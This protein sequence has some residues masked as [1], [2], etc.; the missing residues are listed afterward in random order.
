[1]VSMADYNFRS[2]SSRDFE[3]LA[4][5]LLQA[6][7]KHRL[8]SF[9]S[10]PDSGIDFRYQDKNTKLIVQ[11]KHYAESGFAA[12]TSA[13]RRKERQKIDHLAPTRYVLA[14][15][16]S[17]SPANKDEIMEILAPYCHET[18]DIYGQEDLNNLLSQY[19]DIERK[20][21]KLWLTSETVLRRVLDAGIFSDSDAH[22]ER[23]RL[24]LRR[25][26]PNPSFQR[27]V[28]LLD[29][30]HYCIIAGIPGIGKTT[31]AQVLLADLVD[32]QGFEA[33]RIAHDLDEIRAVKNSKRKQVFYFDDFLGKT[34]LEKLQKNED[35]RLVELIEEVVLNQNWRF[36][37]TTR[38]YILNRAKFSYEAFAQ[39]PVDFTP[40]VIKLDDYTRLI[41]AKIL[42]N[43]I[44]FSELPKAHKLALLQKKGYENILQHRNYNPRVIEYMTQKLHACAVAPSIYLS[45]FTDS[46]EHPTRIWD[47]AFRF[48]ISEAARHVLLVLATLPN[49]IL[50]TDLENS[51][52]TF[53]RFRQIRFGFPT[54]SEDW[55]RALKELDGNFITTQRVGDKISVSF[56]NPSIRDFLEDFLSNSERDV[57]DLVSGAHFY[58]Q[59]VNL[60][61]GRGGHRYRAINHHH[62]EF[63]RHLARN[64]FGPTASAIRQL[65]SHN[66]V[67]GLKHR[68]VSNESRTGFALRVCKELKHKG[69]DQFLKEILDTLETRWE[70]GQGDKE[71]LVRLL[72]S[73]TDY[74]LDRGNTAFVMAKQC[75]SSKTE[76]IEDFRALAKFMAMYP[77]EV[78]PTDLEVLRSKFLEFAREYSEGWDDDPDWLREAAGDLEL[79]G[80]TL[81]VDVTDFTGKLYSS[82]NDIESE[83][84]DAEP[85]TNDEEPWDPEES[86]SAS[87]RDDVH[88]MFEGLREEIEN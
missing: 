69:G 37:L 18:S 14:T 50:L 48:Q 29:R 66:E 83:R 12:L 9:S 36:I 13:L 81:E 6:N 8:E 30:S 10:G 79:I 80:E 74:G 82:A 72:K 68:A 27:A 53:Y 35:Q 51:F 56:H 87:S 71:D 1:M 62:E 45:E 40:C 28:E 57:L 61:E 19:P 7:I 32:R 58:E 59:Y 20:H 46:L 11:C 60:W 86:S 4:R 85:E 24:R 88:D 17:L 73:L 54:A 25:Y 38:E 26:V 47:H 43:H 41:R 44:Y 34:T 31:L 76:G 23:I 84:A 77:E 65:N 55:N 3:L 22:L 78:L 52:W 42:Y 70:R 39:P 67:I 33:F 49:E 21:F 16:V 75:L 15:S 64:I 2:L 63:L 5:D